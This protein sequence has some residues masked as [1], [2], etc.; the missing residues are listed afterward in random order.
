N[1]TRRF[2]RTLLVLESAFFQSLHACENDV[3]PFHP[4]TPAPAPENPRPSCAARSQ[5][6]PLRQI[7]SRQSEH[8][9]KALSSNKA[10]SA[11]LD[12]TSA[13][14]SV[15]PSESGRGLPH[16]KTCGILAHSVSREASWSAPVLWRF[17]YCGRGFNVPWHR[18]RCILWRIPF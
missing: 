3:P 15:F 10:L 18:S 17:G 16:S 4:C 7:H 11:A 8:A 1:R 5:K 9:H 12:W 13:T 2:L 6:C 14:Y